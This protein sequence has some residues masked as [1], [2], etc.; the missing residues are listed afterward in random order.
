MIDERDTGDS[1]MVDT[2]VVV[3]NCHVQHVFWKEN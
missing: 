1:V 2:V 3:R